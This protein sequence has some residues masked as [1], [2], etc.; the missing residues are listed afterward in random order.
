MS[1]GRYDAVTTPGFS[2]NFTYTSEVLVAPE[3]MLTASIN[4]TDRTPTFAPYQN[5]SL[6]GNQTVTTDPIFGRYVLYRFPQVPMDATYIAI[7][8][9]YTSAASG[10]IGYGASWPITASPENNFECAT[11]DGVSNLV[12]SNYVQ[13]FICFSP[14]WNESYYLSINSGMEVHMNAT[15]LAVV[16]PE[17][18]TGPTCEDPVFP[19]N[20]RG[21]A[22]QYITG[23]SAS[24]YAHVYFDVPA[25]NWNTTVLVAQASTLLWSDVIY[26]R[27]NTYSS[28]TTN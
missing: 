21:A 15:F 13:R 22:V 6:V 19:Y 2:C 1:A 11:Y 14:R 18:L 23:T 25:R 26:L 17:G 10:M 12:G 27:D 3:G 8:L 24:G 7:T 9:T 16:C 5:V 28:A 4:T 20:L